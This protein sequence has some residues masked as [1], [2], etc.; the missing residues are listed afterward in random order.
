MI[1]IFDQSKDLLRNHITWVRPAPPFNPISRNSQIED[2]SLPL[3]LGTLLLGKRGHLCCICL[4]PVSSTGFLPDIFN[5]SLMNECFGQSGACKE[6]IRYWPSA[7]FISIKQS[8]IEMYDRPGHT[9]LQRWLRG[10]PVPEDLQARGRP[11]RQV[12][13]IEP[14]DG[15]MA[16]KCRFWILWLLSGRHRSIL[17]HSRKVT[18]GKGCLNEGK[19]QKTR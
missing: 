16:A 6:P 14:K 1:K 13:S 4:S 12:V 8:L 15:N 3:P 11:P 18:K 2:Q 10:S 19:T 5:N 9:R 7:Q 17:W